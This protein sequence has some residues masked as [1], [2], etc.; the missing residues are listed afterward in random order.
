MGNAKAHGQDL[1][2]YFDVYKHRVGYKTFLKKER[3]SI[4][5]KNL[6][7]RR[8]SINVLMF[9]MVTNDCSK[10]ISKC[11]KSGRVAARHS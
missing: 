10:T 9:L 8:N 2:K 11:F 3:F 1:G 6:F 4:E 7:E 5:T